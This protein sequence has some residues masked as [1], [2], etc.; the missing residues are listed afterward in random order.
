[1]RREIAYGKQGVPV[2]RVDGGS[3]LAC[4]VAV[5]VFGSRFLASYTEGDNRDVVATDSI[6]NFILEESAS[7][8]GTTLEGLLEHLG[9][10]FLQTYDQM[11]A[12]RLS[13]R[14]LGFRQMGAGSSYVRAGGDR[15]GA[16]LG[17][18]RGT[19]GIELTEH[20]CRWTGLE[21]LTTTGSAFSGFVRDHYTT[22]PEREDRPLCLGLDVRWR[23]LEVADALGGTDRHVPPADLRA[24]VVETFAGFRSASIQQLVHQ[25]GL[26][27][28]DRHPGLAQV[29]FEA[30]NLTPAP[31]AR[32]EASG[33]AV[34]SAAF[35]A[36]GTIALVLQREG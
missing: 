3:L 5:E 13:A 15:A 25:M 1:V 9:R 27:L 21:L 32:D 10:G 29:G 36:P 4:D 23:Y 19:G 17:L 31:V 33:R 22:L 2:Y 30:R 12:L 18:R 6:K 16:T 8:P 14:D 11:E 35:P 7:Y 20:E 34:Y 24:E 26:G 28:L